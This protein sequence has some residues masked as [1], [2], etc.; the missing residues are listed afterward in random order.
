MFF[1]CND[2]FKKLVFVNSHELIMRNL[3]TNSSLRFPIRAIVFVFACAIHGPMSKHNDPRCFSSI[4]GFCCLL[5]VILQPMVLSDD[6]M[7]AVIEIVVVFRVN[8]DEMNWPKVKTV[9][10]VSKLT[11]RHCKSVLVVTEVAVKKFNWCYMQ[12]RCVNISNW[13][14]WQKFD[15]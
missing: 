3:N 1:K 4:L 7:E 5:Q 8:A 9:V 11:F 10:H 6:W 15:R 14:V 2:F 13:F 12:L